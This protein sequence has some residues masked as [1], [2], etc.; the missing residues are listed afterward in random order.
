VGCSTSQ[1]VGDDEDK[2]I[3]GDEPAMTDTTRLSSTAISTMS[4]TRKFVSLGMFIIDEFAFADA[5]GKPN[6]RSLSPQESGVF[7]TFS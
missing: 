1:T 5:A 3:T 4:T 6:G 2:G 7:L